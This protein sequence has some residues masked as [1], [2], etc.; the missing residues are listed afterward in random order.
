VLLSLTG[1]AEPGIDGLLARKWEEM[2]VRPAPLCDDAEFLRRASLDLIGR[3]PTLEELRTFVAKPDRAAKI[4]ELL[5]SPDFPRFW[6]ETWTAMLNG[7]ASAFNSQ[8]DGLRFWLEKKFRENAP[9][10]RMSSELIGASGLSSVEGAVNFILHNSVDPAIKISRTFLGIRLDCAR[11]HDHPFDRWT[12]KDYEEMARFFL[13]LQ[14]EELMAGNTRVRDNPD[15]AAGTKPR[16]LTGAQPVTSRWREDLAYFITT[17]KPFARTFANRI[18]YHFMG[19]GIVDP[20]D[21]FSM[22]NKPSVPALLDFLAEEATRTKFDLR[23]MIRTIC[24]SDAYRRSSRRDARD[25]RLESVFA[26]RVLKPMTPE[27]LFDSLVAA[28]DGSEF[29]KRREAF[30]RT[31]VGRSFGEDFSN[32]WRYRETVQD[33]M[34]KLTL[35]PKTPDGSLDELYLRILS[36][37]PNARERELCRGRAPAEIVFALANSNEFYFNH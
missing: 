35:D 10:D 24:T 16:F 27:Q 25:P 19:R 29:K 2:G 22:K 28:L 17:S 14:K 15:R 11:C 3:V 34:T 4:D 32:V 21:D 13:P 23:A 31:F 36:R 20:P 1:S 18:W 26:Y 30:I 5:A 12:Q 9:Y 6:S 7:Y 8:R 33:V 37:A